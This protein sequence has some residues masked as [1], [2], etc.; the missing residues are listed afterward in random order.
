MLKHCLSLP[1]FRISEHID[2]L[3]E[4]NDINLDLQKLLE[5]SQADVD[6][7]VPQNSSQNEFYTIFSNSD[8][9]KQFSVVKEDQIGRAHV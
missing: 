3:Y 9:M 2:E 7:T 8:F 1:S 5:I 6:S 4:A